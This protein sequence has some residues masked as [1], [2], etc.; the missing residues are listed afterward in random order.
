M[1]KHL[2][3]LKDQWTKKGFFIDPISDLTPSSPTDDI[4][5]EIETYF[6]GLNESFTL[7][8]RHPV[9][10]ENNNVVYEASVTNPSVAGMGPSRP[11][12]P[13]GSVIFCQQVK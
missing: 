9:T 5:S 3:S 12:L 13:V 1:K 10:F 4:I 7:I 6:S 2:Q 8:S 11:T